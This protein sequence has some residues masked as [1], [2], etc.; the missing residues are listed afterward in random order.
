MG[1]ELHLPLNARP[2]STLH[3][4]LAPRQRADPEPV[5]ATGAVSAFSQCAHLD[6]EPAAAFAPSRDTGCGPMW[7]CSS[8]PRGARVSRV[9]LRSP[10]TGKLRSTENFTVLFFLHKR[11]AENTTS[12]KSCCLQK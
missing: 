12:N 7:L 10:L 11:I 8:R 5:G 9:L 3:W 6:S 2:Q 4:A 1:A